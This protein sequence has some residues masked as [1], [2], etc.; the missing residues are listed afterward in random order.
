[1]SYFYAKA[2]E[3]AAAPYGGLADDGGRE[4]GRWRSTSGATATPARSRRSARRR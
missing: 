3:Q 1:M 2:R 4:G